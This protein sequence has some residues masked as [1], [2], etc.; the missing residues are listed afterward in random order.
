M[1]VQKQMNMD[2][3]KKETEKKEILQYKQNQRAALRQQLVMYSIV[4]ISPVSG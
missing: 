2:I 3:K 4:L 1:E